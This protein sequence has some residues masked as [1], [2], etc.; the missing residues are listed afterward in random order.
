MHGTN[1]YR[2]VQ[3]RKHFYSKNKTKQ[4]KT[5]RRREEVAN[6]ASQGNQTPFNPKLFFKSNK[7]E[8]RM[9]SAF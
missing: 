4:N 3:L 8:R 2:L 7:K 1:K 6:I 9:L 5:E